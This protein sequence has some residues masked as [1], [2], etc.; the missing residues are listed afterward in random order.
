MI[1]VD[2]SIVTVALIDDGPD[3]AKVRAVLS[4]QALVAPELIDL[5]VLSVLR[6]Q[7][8]ARAM[9]V[10]RAELALVDLADLPMKRATHRSLLARCWEL[11]G[12]VRAYDAAYVAL[13]EALEV[14]LVTA[15]RR[16]A[17]SPGIGCPVEVIS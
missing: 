12:S 7:V 6:R 5:E 13:A 14:P 16:L 11:R 3:G 15:D 1:V 9:T 10:R 4:G 2:A 8:R 17:R